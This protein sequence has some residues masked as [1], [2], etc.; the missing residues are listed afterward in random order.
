M[1]KRLHRVQDSIREGRYRLSS[2]AERE[3]EAELI[4]KQELEEAL[5]SANAEI[6]EDY[7][8]DPRGP[9][10]LVLGF[11][12]QG[13]PLHAVIGLAEAVVIITVYRPTQDEWIGWRQRRGEQT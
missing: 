3:R 11:T 8:D 7:S 1:R 4:T 5:L 6:I 10:C 13:K 12:Q 2:H 9:S